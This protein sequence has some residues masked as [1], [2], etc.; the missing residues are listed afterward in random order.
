MSFFTLLANDPNVSDAL[1]RA[2]C[3]ATHTIP[4]HQIR[5]TPEWEARQ[6]DIRDQ[7]HADHLRD[8]SHERNE[9]GE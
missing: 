2:F 5:G 9:R 3:E 6:Q 8:L 7:E 1:K 4:A